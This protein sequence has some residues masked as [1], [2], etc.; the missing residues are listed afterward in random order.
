MRSTLTVRG[1]LGSAAVVI[2]SVVFGVSVFLVLIV[3][4]NNFV[5]FSDFEFKVNL[6]EPL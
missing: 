5:R 3:V 4:H 2:G 1:R 6:V